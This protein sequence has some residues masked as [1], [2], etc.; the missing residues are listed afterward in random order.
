LVVLSGYVAAENRQYKNN[1]NSSSAASE[2]SS[3]YNYTTSL[4]R[5][6]LIPYNQ[7]VCFCDNGLCLLNVKHRLPTSLLKM[8]LFF[9]DKNKGPKFSCF[10][11]LEQGF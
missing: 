4:Q 9:F 2:I 1:K 10:W 7:D 3:T 6:T 8:P 5:R 11:F